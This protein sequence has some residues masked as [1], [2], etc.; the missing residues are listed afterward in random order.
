[1]SNP[2]DPLAWVAYAE[3]DWRVARNILRYKKPSTTLACFHARQC[4]E[5]YLKALLL[6][7]GIFP[8][9]TH[10]LNYLD[11]LYQQHG[12]LTRF[13]DR[14]LTL[15]TDYAVASRYPGDAPSLEEAREAI[16]V[17]RAVRRF[18]RAYLGVK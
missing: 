3:D 13:S 1:M 11:D 9:R 18:A 2:N 12:I 6:S 10:D 5:K 17:A 15:L 16:R 7:R 8:P 14:A 4:A